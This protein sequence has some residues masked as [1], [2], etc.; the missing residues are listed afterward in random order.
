[1]SDVLTLTDMRYIL[2][3]H[4]YALVE[5]DLARN[6]EFPCRWMLHD[7]IDKDGFCIVGDDP[8][9][10]TREAYRHIFEEM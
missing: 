6:P 8:D 2:L 5:R 10:L 1:M 7:A 9:E 3:C 4:D